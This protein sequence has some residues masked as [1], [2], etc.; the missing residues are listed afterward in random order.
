[1]LNIAMEPYD[2]WLC[3]LDKCAV[4]NSGVTCFHSVV[5]S[6]MSMLKNGEAVKYRWCHPLITY[7]AVSACTGACTGSSICM[8]RDTGRLGGTHGVMV[9]R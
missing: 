9:A 5:G 1:M 2:L 4:L 8:S 3:H 7:M 6:V